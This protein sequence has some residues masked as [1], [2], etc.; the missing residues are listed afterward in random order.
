M[1]L[2][3]QSLTHCAWKY[4]LLV[5]QRA[6]WLLGQTAEDFQ[7]SIFWSLV[8][9]IEGRGG[10]SLVFS[11]LYVWGG[12]KRVLYVVYAYGGQKLTL[13]VVPQGLLYRPVLCQLD[14]S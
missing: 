1:S 6:G 12:H 4:G 13:C 7:V 10:L 11:C 2:V 8:K 14:A 9:C 5:W 3:A